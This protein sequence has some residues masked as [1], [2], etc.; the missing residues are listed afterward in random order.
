M[1]GAKSLKLLWLD[2]EMSGLDVTKEVPIEV[3]ALVTDG[4]FNELGL[5]HAI[6][7]QPQ[8]YIDGMDEWNRK[9]H[10]GS[11]L[12][13]LIPNGKEPEHV[14]QE[15]ATLIRH[16]FG[17]E[18][19]ILCGNSIGQDRLFIRRYMPLTEATLHYRMID[20]TSWKVIYNEIYGVRF[21]KKDAHRALDDIRES[22]AELQFYMSFVQTPTL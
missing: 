11:G 5:Y 22:M 3:A 9:Q 4:Q 20:V 6:I 13:D 2:M 7:K 10:G 8:A 15:L 16:H 17:S 21:K 18:R 1:S 12:I 14:D 19:A